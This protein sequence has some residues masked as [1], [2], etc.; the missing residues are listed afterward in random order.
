MLGR[1]H[2]GVADNEAFLVAERQDRLE[3]S[4]TQELRQQQDAAYLESLKADQEK[5]R[6]KREAE[7][8]K[9]QEEAEKQRLIDEER[10]RKE[11]SL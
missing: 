7:E 3:R 9:R 5:D 2:Q 10:Q 11:V 4:M 1:L 6:K 8:K